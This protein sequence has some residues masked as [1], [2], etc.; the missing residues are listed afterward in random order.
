MT[1]LTIE[2]WMDEL[3]C[4]Q[5][6]QDNYDGYMTINDIILTFGWSRKTV[7]RFLRRIKE[8]GGLTVKFKTVESIC[9]HSRKVPVY[10]FASP[11]KKKSK[12]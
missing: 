9:G 8:I 11:K 2:E 12:K 5:K 10:K 6:E 7:E 3:S 4:L 1:D